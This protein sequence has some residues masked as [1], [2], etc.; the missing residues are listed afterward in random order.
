[1]TFVIKVCVNIASSPW[2]GHRGSPTSTLVNS[3]KPLEPMTTL[4][5]QLLLQLPLMT[6]LVVVVVKTVGRERGSY[7]FPSVI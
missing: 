3:P 7:L 6:V 1:M 4:T 5:V 2:I